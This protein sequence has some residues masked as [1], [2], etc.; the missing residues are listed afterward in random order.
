MKR[1]AFCLLFAVF[2]VSSCQ[3]SQDEV[4]PNGDDACHGEQGTD[5]G[6]GEQQVPT[7][8][9]ELPPV[10]A[11]YNDY[12]VTLEIDP[13][14]RSVYGFSKVVFTN[15]TGQSLNEIVLRTFLNAFGEGFEPAPFFPEHEHRVF[16][17]GFPIRPGYSPVDPLPFAYEVEDYDDAA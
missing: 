6:G 16:R 12:F 13:D 9:E 1:L 15:R 11:P 17:G 4:F 10:V 2:L 14:E 7:E 5:P 3:A 8:P